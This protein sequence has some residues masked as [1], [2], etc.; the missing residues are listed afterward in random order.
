[1]IGSARYLIRFDDLCPTMNWD[2]W[3]KLERAL[4][5]RGVHPLLAV[6]PDNQDPKLAV[7]PAN[8]GFWEEVRNWQARG[9]TIGLHG[10]QHRFVTQN[11]GILGIQRRS[12]FAGLPSAEQA[13]KLR[14]AVDIFREQGIQPEIWIAPAHSFD[15]NTVSALAKL[16][17][18]VINDGLAMA[19]HTD[20]RGIFW[21]PQ[22]LWRFR[23]R[24][25]GLWT[26]CCHH[27][28]WSELQ[29]QQFVADLD[30]YRDSMTDLSAV[31]SAY[32]SRQRS[33]MDNFYSLAHSTVL[34]SRA[35]WRAAR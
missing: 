3:A 7:G 8:P 34:F 13:E 9:W 20:T 29:L 14:R 22:Q 25:A 35:Q 18:P 1:M 27:N 32:A 26:I 23:W 4:I 24:P 5:E 12:E 19:P 15:W 31:K 21:V 11:G 16:G 30:R 17:L 2:M 6:V 28:S 33:V 10:Y